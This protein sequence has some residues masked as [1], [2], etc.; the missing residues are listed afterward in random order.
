MNNHETAKQMAHNPYVCLCGGDEKY[1]A[2]C[3][4]LRG[5]NNKSQ[6]FCFICKNRLSPNSLNY[7][8]KKCKHLI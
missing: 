3:E 1:K 2:K 5:H 8:H 4:R 6:R 7:V